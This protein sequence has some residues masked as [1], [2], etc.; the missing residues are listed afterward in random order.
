MDGRIS[1]IEMTEGRISKSEDRSVEITQ[2]EEEW[3]NDGRKNQQSGENTCNIYGRQKFTI[4]NIIKYLQ[5]NKKN[6][7]SKKSNTP[8]MANEQAI[9]TRNVNDHSTCENS[10]NLTIIKRKLKRQIPLHLLD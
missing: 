3:E 9:F 1:R 2:T 5:S 4:T 7:Q 6:T 8:I 10:S